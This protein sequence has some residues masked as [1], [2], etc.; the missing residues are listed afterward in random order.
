MSNQYLDQDQFEQDSN[1][2]QLSYPLQRFFE[3]SSQNLDS[4]EHM[5]LRQN[6]NWYCKQCE[7]QY[8][9]QASFTKHCISIHNSSKIYKN[10]LYR[11]IQIGRPK[12]KQSNK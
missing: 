1:Q 7:N 11:R 5:L 3:E 10:Q 9:N 12:G 2:S 8:A 6:R 4:Y